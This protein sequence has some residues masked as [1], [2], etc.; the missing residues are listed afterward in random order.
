MNIPTPPIVDL[1]QPT[2]HNGLRLLEW[3]TKKL[4]NDPRPVFRVWPVKKS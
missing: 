1:Q 2:P 4:V 3:Q